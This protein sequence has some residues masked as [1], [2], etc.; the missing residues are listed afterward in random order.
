MKEIIKLAREYL[1]KFLEPHHFRNGYLYTFRKY[2]IH[3]III[4]DE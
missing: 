4:R 3:T 1:L 2:I